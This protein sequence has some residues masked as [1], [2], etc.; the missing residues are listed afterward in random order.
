MKIWTD[1]SCEPNPGP[2]G[3]GYV[4]DTGIEAC[5]GEMATTNNRMEMMAILMALRSIPTGAAV[6]ICSDSMYCVNGLTK[7]NKKWAQAK[8]MRKGEAI[9]NRDLWMDLEH[10]K[11]RVFASFCWVRGHN[12]DRGNEAADALANRGRNGIIVPARGSTAAPTASPEESTLGDIRITTSNQAYDCGCDHVLP[13]DDCEHTY[14][15]ASAA[16]NEIMAGVMP[17]KEAGAQ[18]TAVH[19][20]L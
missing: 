7:W 8:W 11:A 18:Q 3:W 4:T 9:P 19:S 14:A 13:W 2:G 15:A 10:E 12:G 1:G 5:G 20:R 6:T 17:N 16:F